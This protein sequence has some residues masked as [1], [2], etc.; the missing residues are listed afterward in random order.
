MS[1]QSCFP[2]GKSCTHGFTT[3]PCLRAVDLVLS[4]RTVFSARPGKFFKTSG[5]S[6]AR[7][8]ERQWFVSEVCEGVQL[9]AY[10][11]L[12]RY[13]V[14]PKPTRDHAKSEITQT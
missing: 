1:L 3:C 13:A 5:K 11:I 12:E 4:L 14:S 8:P 6:S 9:F 7:F 10:W 2:C